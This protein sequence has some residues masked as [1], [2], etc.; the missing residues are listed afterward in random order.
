M[1]KNKNMI[2]KEIILKENWPTGGQKDVVTQLMILCCKLIFEVRLQKVM[3]GKIL[4][5]K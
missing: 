1:K 4:K 2:I 5:N 3:K